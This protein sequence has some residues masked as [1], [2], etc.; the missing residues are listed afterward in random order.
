MFDLVI[1]GGTVIDGSGGAPRTADVAVKDGVIVSVEGKVGP[2]TREVQADGALVTPG[3]VDI[4]THY[5]GQATWDADLTPSSWHGVTTTVFGNCGVG[6]APV[7]P[8]SEPYLIN[9]MEGVEDIPEIVLSEGIDFRWESFPDFLNVLAE[10]DRTMD[11]GTQ[12]PHA[13]LRFYCMG[14]RGSDHGSM[15]T[16]EEIKRMGLLLE[17][18]LC[19]GALGFSTSRTIKHKAADGRFTPSLTAR[20]P[21]LVGLAHAMKRAG[22]GIIQVNSDFEPGDFETLRAVAAESTR[23]LSVLLIQVD[24][25]PDRWLDT[26]A[27]IRAAN[28]A[29][30]KVNGQVASRP[31]GILM[32]LETSVHPFMTHRTWRALA[33]LTPAERYQRLKNDAD[34]RDRLINE[35]PDNGHTKWMDFAMTRACRLQEPLDYEPDLTN[36]I[37]ALAEREGVDP[38]AKALEM[39]MEQ[40][41]KAIMLYP[42]ENYNAGNLDVI[43]EMLLD[44]ETVCGVAD[45]GAHVGLICDSSSPTTLMTLWGRDRKRGEGIPLPHLVKKQTRDT[46]LTYGLTDRGLLAPGMKADIN[47]IDF[48]N[49]RALKPE[50]VYDMPAGGKRLIQRS[51]GY[52]H[53]FVSGIET[54]NN[55][56]LTGNRPGRLIRG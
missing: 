32:G 42:F 45:G 55:S 16:E 27:G 15:P 1:R 36:S 21:E 40:D 50:V 8:G 49:L 11:I 23:P 52:R 26:R 17:E 18:A 10:T 12:V 7:K 34:L 28:A 25:A 14:D 54:L 39:L 2:A 56:E 3:W 46:A 4:H 6:F 51:S 20:E 38:W 33:D 22:R 43:R 9:L 47:V 30:Q 29:G 41:G 37:A 24:N 13:A 44:P 5:D 35:R 31:I 19:A 48:D 53:T